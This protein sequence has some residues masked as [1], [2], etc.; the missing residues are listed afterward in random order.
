MLLSLAAVG[1]V[2]ANVTVPGIFSD[3]A[4]LQKSGA[5]AVF[6]KAAPGE[7][8]CVSYGSASASTV[9]G[10]DGKWLVRLDLSNSDKKYLCWTAVLFL[11]TVNDHAE[12]KR[13]TA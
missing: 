2:F 3:K 5:T 7:Q 10:K 8:V 1:T 11:R 4:V 9:A 6:G 12:Q 13:R